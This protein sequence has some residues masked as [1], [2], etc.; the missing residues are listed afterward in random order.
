L[1]QKTTFNYIST[2]MKFVDHFH[3]S[4]CYKVHNTAFLRL[5]LP[6]VGGPIAYW[7]QLKTWGMDFPMVVAPM[8]H[9]ITF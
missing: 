2:L 6:K 3:H 7:S 9:S 5:V 8:I 4:I 1:F